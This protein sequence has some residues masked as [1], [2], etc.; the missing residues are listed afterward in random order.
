ML[1]DKI[2]AVLIA[3]TAS[4]A[5]GTAAHDDSTTSVVNLNKL[6]SEKGQ[7][8]M[9]DTIFGGPDFD[10]TKARFEV[11]D[12][13]SY[14]LGELPQSLCIDRNRD[15]VINEKEFQPG[16]G[17]NFT[18]D[19]AYVQ[20]NDGES[21]SNVDLH[22]NPKNVSTIMKGSTVPVNLVMVYSKSGQ[23]GFVYTPND[24][25]DIMVMTS[26]VYT[27]KSDTPKATAPC[28]TG[29]QQQRIP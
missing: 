18:Y 1:K 26:P 22:N 9:D 19:H 27:Y 2:K 7:K 23:L 29:P 15:G 13:K 6:A 11:V 20:F 10:R 4:G 17:F 28:Y 25:G 3:I 21:L 14:T 5:F 16:N 24:K 8:L 12:P